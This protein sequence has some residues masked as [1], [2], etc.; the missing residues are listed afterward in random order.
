MSL[1][2]DIRDIIYDE[3]PVNAHCPNCDRDFDIDTVLPSYKDASA[4]DKNMWDNL[5]LK[6]LEVVA[7]CAV[8]DIVREILQER[9]RL[10]K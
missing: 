6:I 5:T 2:D 9:R 10:G 7:N 8:S 3:V 4:R 1:S